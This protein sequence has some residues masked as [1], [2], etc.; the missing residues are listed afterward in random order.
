MLNYTKLDDT[1][2]DLQLQ[3]Y[4]TKNIQYHHQNTTCSYG[5]VQVTVTRRFDWRKTQLKQTQTYSN[6]NILVTDGSLCVCTSLLARNRADI[7]V[8]QQ[9]QI[10][11]QSISIY[12]LEYVRQCRQLERALL[13]E[14]DGEGVNNW[15]FELHAHIEIVVNVPVCSNVA[16]QVDKEAVGDLGSHCDG[17]T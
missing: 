12:K 15:K 6:N 11:L 5:I 7:Q 1:C 4:E 13:V 9:K 8:Y 17:S 14:G 3:K 16:H 10:S 2:L